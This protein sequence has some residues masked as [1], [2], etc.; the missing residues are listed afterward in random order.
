MK[1]LDKIDVIGEI[2]N[3]YDSINQ[4]RYENEKLRDNNRLLHMKKDIAKQ[5]WLTEFYKRARKDIWD[6]YGERR[7]YGDSVYVRR[8][9]DG[10][11]EIQTFEEWCDEYYTSMPPFMC[12]NDFK[13]EYHD[14][15]W[16]RYETRRKEALEKLEEE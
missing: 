6:E 1:N 2:V 7:W 5:P 15:L 11:T 13:V 12:L 14:E 16:Q 4:L 8:T 3:L 10:E 9:P